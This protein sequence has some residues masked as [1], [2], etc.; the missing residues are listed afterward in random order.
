MKSAR[1]LTTWR[2][3][4]VI[5]NSIFTLNFIGVAFQPAADTQIHQVAANQRAQPRSDQQGVTA[6]TDEAQQTTQTG[7]ASK[8]DP[9]QAKRKDDGRRGS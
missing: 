5:N 8:A 2:F 7:D 1:S 9:E 3:S 6:H 4:Y